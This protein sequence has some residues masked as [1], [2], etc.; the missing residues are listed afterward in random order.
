MVMGRLEYRTR[1]GASKTAANTGALGNFPK[2]P[3]MHYHAKS[4][5]AA[6]ER[7]E[8]QPMARCSVAKRRAIMRI[9]AVVAVA[10]LLSVAAGPSVPAQTL[11]D[12]NPQTKWSPPRSLAKSSPSRRAKSC[13][14]YGAG[15]VNVPGTDACIKI[16]G[17]VSMEAG[18]QGR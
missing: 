3:K 5:M 14:S 18:S 8:D 6:A 9:G 2:S 12:P 15:F 16:G 4:K 1:P 10:G 11:T 13:S 17:F 7:Q